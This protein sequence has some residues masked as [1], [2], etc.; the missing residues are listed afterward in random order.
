MHLLQIWIMPEKRGIEPS[1]EQKNFPVEEK[2][3]KL[4]L[5]ASSDAKDGSVK[6]N[7]DAKL[8]VSLLEPGQEVQHE[9]TKDRHAWVQVAKGAIELNGKKLNQGDGAAVSDETSLTLKGTA[10]AEILLFDLA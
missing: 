9:L 2:Q 10:N 6:I 1:Y 8:Y 5:I 4:R 3:G 7:Q